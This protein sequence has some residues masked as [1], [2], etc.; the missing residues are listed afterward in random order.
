LTQFGAY[1]RLNPE[2]PRKLG[3]AGAGVLCLTVDAFE[4][5]GAGFAVPAGMCFDNG[6]TERVI[7]RTPLP[8]PVQAGMHGCAGAMCAESRF[9]EGEF[10]G[11]VSG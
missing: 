4:Q 11:R 9:A 10:E 8:L 3:H 7:D 2:P 1:R 5:A 6:A